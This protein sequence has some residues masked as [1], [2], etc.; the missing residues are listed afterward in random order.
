M[1]DQDGNFLE[2]SD[3]GGMKEENKNSD[4]PLDL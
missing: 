3:L 1:V 4:D 2:N